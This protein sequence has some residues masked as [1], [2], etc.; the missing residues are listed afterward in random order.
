MTYLIIMISFLS[1]YYNDGKTTCVNSEAHCLPN[2][3]IK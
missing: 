2:D 3:E 1:K